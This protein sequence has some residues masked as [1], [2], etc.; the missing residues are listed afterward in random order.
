M[1]L[2][3]I[4]KVDEMGVD[5]MGTDELGVDE[6]GIDQL[7]SYRST[8]QVKCDQGLC[9][10]AIQWCDGNAECQDSSDEKP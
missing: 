9:I 7:G 3:S 6:M 2:L 4:F 8:G 10:P 1:A 5:E